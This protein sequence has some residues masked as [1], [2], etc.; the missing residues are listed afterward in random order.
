MRMDGRGD[1]LAAH[2]DER[3]CDVAARGQPSCSLSWSSIVD[4][5]LVSRLSQVATSTS[6]SLSVLL[7]IALLWI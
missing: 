3:G 7:P 4:G 6:V 1:N 5:R 2:F